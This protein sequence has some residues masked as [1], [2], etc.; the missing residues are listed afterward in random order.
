MAERLSRLLATFFYAGYFP[1]APGTF[2]SLV[3]LLIFIWLRPWPGVYLAAT[4][5]ITAIGFMTCGQA[6]KSFLHHDPPQ[7]VIDEVA[8]VLLALYLFP[9]KLPLAVLAFLIFRGLDMVKPAPADQ[10]QSLPGSLGIMLDD[11]V[12][13]LYTFLVFQLAFRVILFNAS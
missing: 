2:A 1:L 3:G 10:M 7:V 11:I 8:G 9:F 6:E 5:I 4:L 13:G 12:A